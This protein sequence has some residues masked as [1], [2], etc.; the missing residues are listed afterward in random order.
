MQ[1]A[2]LPPC[3]AF[4][5]SDLHNPTR[6]INQSI[7]IRPNRSMYLPTVN[8]NVDVIDFA[9]YTHRYSELRQIEKNKKLN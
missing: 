6:T 7:N 1:D 3:S 9:I 2:E 5:E 4:D 8:V